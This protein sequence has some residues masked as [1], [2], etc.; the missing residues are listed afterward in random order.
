LTNLQQRFLLVAGKGGVG[1][2]TCAAAI[3]LLRADSQQTCLVSTDPAGSLN[4]V[5]NSPTANHQPPTLQVTQ[6]DADQAFQHWRDQYRGQVRSVFERLGLDRSAQLDQNVIEQLWNLAPPGIDEIAALTELLNAA[7]TCDTTVLDSAPTGHF[8]RLL[9][10]PEIAVDWSHALMRILLKYHL[11]G[12]LEPLTRDLLEFARRTREL[13]RDLTD[14]S[15]SA[16][17]LVALDEPVVWAETARLHKALQD[18]KIPIAALVVNRVRAETSGAGPDFRQTQII[19]APYLDTPVVGPAALR[20]FL[21]QWE[22]VACP[23]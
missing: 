6:L 22:L 23:T 4:E 5:L 13:H 19:H 1:K 8:L 10:M 21:A 17:I 12:S 14:A 16:A 2:S 20:D 15:R 18:A 7:A 3:A 11:A 9:S